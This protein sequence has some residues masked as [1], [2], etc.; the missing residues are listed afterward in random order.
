[1]RTSH[2]LKSILL[3]ATALSFAGPAF[4]QDADKAEEASGND[5]V[6]VAQRVEE[7]LQDVPV[8]VTVLN[9]K[10][11]SNN[12]ITSAK[13]IATFTPSLVTNNR[14]GNDNTTW[15]IRGFTQEQRT[16]STVGTYF[17]DVVAP[18][19]SGAT[20]G[21]D[22]AGPG[23]LFDL[24]SVQVLNGP[25]G[26]L[27]GRNSTG[28]AVLLVP[29]R[30]TSEFEGYVEGSIGD[31]DLRRVQAVVN[32]P[33]MDSLRIRLGVDRNK[34]DGYLINAGKIGFGPFGDA[35]GSVDYTALRFSA[36]A[37]LSPDVEN[38]TIVNYSKSKSTGNPPKILDCYNLV[39]CQQKVYGD[40][41][42][43]W[44]VFNTLP[45]AGSKT[46]TWQIIN[47]TKWQVNDN[48]TLKNIFS[49][50][51]YV[52][53]LNID[54]FGQ[55]A[56]VPSTLA[57]GSET[58]ASQVKPFNVTHK[59]PNE[60]TN[61]QSSL[62]EEIQL[63]GQ[64]TDG[65]LTYQA[66]LY[67]ESNNPL[68][69]SGIQSTTFTPCV[70]IN[71]INCTGFSGGG[72]NSLGRLSYSTTMNYFD[73]RAVYAQASYNASEKLKFTGGFRYTWDTMRSQFQ[74]IDLRLANTVNASAVRTFNANGSV[75][76]P[77]PMI[78]NGTT[79][80]TPQTNVDFAA[81]TNFV[82]FG[83]QGSATNPFQPIANRFGMCKQDITAKSSKPTWLLGVDFKPMED[84]LVYA[85]WS[86]G[87]RQAGVASFAADQLQKYNAEKVDTYEAGLKASW[88]GMIPGF[89]NISGFYNNFR[90]QQVQLGVQ[91]IPTS[92]CSQTT[93]IQNVGKSKLTG[94][95]AELGIKP[96]T[97]L[98]LGVA[99]A[100]LR[101]RIIEVNGTKDPKVAISSI[102]S[103]ISGLGLPFNDIRPP[104][105]GQELPNSIPDKIVA[106]GSY[107]FPLPESVG[108]LTVSATW[109]WQSSY[110]AVADSTAGCVSTQTA[111]STPL[112]YYNST[113]PGTFGACSYTP[114]P[115]AADLNPATLSFTSGVSTVGGGRIP[116]QNYGNINVTWE[117]IGGL[118]VDLSA[119]VTNVTNEKI[120]LHLN[121][122]E[123]S[124][125]RSGFIGEPRMYGFRAKVKF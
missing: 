11:L 112:T 67:L 59:L 32:I 21:G 102:S 98:Q 45:D 71:T 94:F 46:E 121:T 76:T 43:F 61:S 118:P 63:Q 12:N 125:L 62:V 55:Y 51:E 7:R 95:E 60:H 97:G 18:R 4:A 39:A 47:Q 23:Y 10:L 48:L 1:M 50:G 93:I 31:Y 5:I 17:G 79:Y 38:Y 19:G 86:R 49:Y 35:G 25:Q 34:R 75:A 104:L 70:D 114:L 88:R 73:G 90:D 8:S 13:D 124:G 100:H 65:A 107:T 96:F 29:K 99:W 80:T 58:N 106:N 84:V 77:G 91:C 14:Y 53:D 120:I 74:V 116:K 44:T 92:L 119:Y 15:T 41:T 52:G 85:K 122:Q 36:V 83:Y 101:T 110:K 78:I 2:G 81:C 40:T 109:V 16:T 28:G 57:Y 30:P 64:T 24:S 68:G 56:L 42:G 82:T 87:Y 3:A 115:S 22:G 66:G 72:A 111:T 89:F 6:V 27:F 54:L 37:D 9:E 69:L 117:N 103:Q 105:P 108:K 33:V 123:T 26:T 20:Q 113:T